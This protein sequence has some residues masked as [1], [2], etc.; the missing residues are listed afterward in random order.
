MHAPTLNQL[1]LDIRPDSPPDFANFLAG[2]NAEALAAVQAHAAGATQEPVLYLWGEPGA[3]KSHLLKAW[4]RATDFVLGNKASNE[5]DIAKLARANAGPRQAL[6]EPP[7]PFVAV[8]DVLQLDGEA[9]IRLFSLINAAREGDGIIIASG[10]L[11]PA[12]LVTATEA[13]FRADLAT[14]LAQ[15]LVFRLHPLSDSDKRVA[16]QGHAASRGLQ[17]PDEVMRYM[18]T[19]CQRDLP[20]LLRLVDLLDVYSLSLKRM[21]SLPLLKEVLQQAE[22][23]QQT[24]KSAAR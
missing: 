20:H 13:P 22:V 24:E 21:L 19:H 2:P 5:R 11:P 16:M 1:I 6:P 8:D 18:L 15:G 23:L 3:G 14:R 4:C 17:L 10:P 12:Q 7:Q 9:Q